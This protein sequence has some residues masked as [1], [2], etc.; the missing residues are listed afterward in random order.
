MM[1]SPVRAA[2]AALTGLWL[3]GCTAQ[4]TPPYEE[5][6]LRDALQAD[7]E[8]VSAVPE[9]SRKALAERMVREHEALHGAQRIA[10]GEPPTPRQPALTPISLVTR[11]DA[12]RSERGADAWMLVLVQVE[13]TTATA[14]PFVPRDARYQRSAA[15]LPP[16]EGEA[17]PAETSDLERRA[18]AGRAGAILRD[19]REESGAA[20]LV[21]VSAWPAGVVALGDA[22]Y[23]NGA[24]LVAMSALDDGAAASGS[25]TVV[26]DA[27]T[28]SGT[29]RPQ[30]NATDAG[31]AETTFGAGVSGGGGGG[32]GGGGSSSSCNSGSSNCGS[33]KSCS[34]S[35][36]SHDSCSGNHGRCKC[37]S[38]AAAEGP[39]APPFTIAAWLFVPALIV[40][41]RGR[42]LAARATRRA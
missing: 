13:K 24:W 39:P 23:V 2:V 33:S 22:L 12:E 5:L 11:L 38:S 10:L 28:W 21:R 6:P 25:A 17:P 18:L 35:S 4:T 20:R 30:S 36:C 26:G 14:R 29:V 16:F 34:S 31:A 32:C 40:S 8:V 7:P 41:A 3:F 1:Q 37:T 27:E 9:G 19:F 15:P 42:R